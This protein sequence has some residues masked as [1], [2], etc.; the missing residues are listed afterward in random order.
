MADETPAGRLARVAFTAIERMR[1]QAMTCHDG[2]LLW[3]G[4]LVDLHPEGES[5]DAFRQRLVDHLTIDHHQE[6]PRH[7]R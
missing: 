7:E 1:A 4:N 6:N 5:L 2:R 3:L